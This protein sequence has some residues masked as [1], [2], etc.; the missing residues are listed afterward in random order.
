MPPQVEDSECGANAT[1]AYG[2]VG[3]VTS[4][5][6]YVI[7]LLWAYLPEQYLEDW[8]VTWYPRKYWA[9]ATPCYIC[10]TVIFVFWFYESLNMLSTPAADSLTTITDKHAQLEPKGRDPG[11]TPPIFDVPI[12]RVCVA[13]Y[14][15]GNRQP[16]RADTNTADGRAPSR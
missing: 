12:A 4:T 11:S 6:A 1:E 7:F 14:G 2:F 5:A 13:L 15:K 16:R 9:V 10:V 3:W 8:G